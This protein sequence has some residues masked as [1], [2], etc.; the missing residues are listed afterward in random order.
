M[1]CPHRQRRCN[2]ALSALS[3]AMYMYSVVQKSVAD[4]EDEEWDED[5]AGDDSGDAAETDDLLPEDDP[6]NE[7]ALKASLEE[8]E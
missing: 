2:H 7:L 4:G 5:Y 1:S 3:A 6:M 8:A